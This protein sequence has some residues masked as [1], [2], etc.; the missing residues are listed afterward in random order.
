M[1]GSLK[2]R[3]RAFVAVP[4]GARFATH[5]QCS[6]RAAAPRWM[7]IATIASGSVLIVLGMAMIVLPGPG[8][9]AIAA[10]GVLLAGESIVAARLLDRV[11]LAAARASGRW[12]ARRARQRLDSPR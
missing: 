2:A 6:Q 3:W 9:L 12:R 7:R 1:T 4:R 10:G 11:D 8:L 5:H